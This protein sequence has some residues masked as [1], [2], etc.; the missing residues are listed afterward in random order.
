[1]YKERSLELEMYLGYKI[2][3]VRTINKQ[4]RT[5]MSFLKEVRFLDTLDGF[6]TTANDENTP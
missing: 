4:P 3:A 6:E 2:T 1:M 5:N